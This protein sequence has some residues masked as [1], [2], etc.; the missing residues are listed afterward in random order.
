MSRPTNALT[1]VSIALATYNGSAF[2]PELLDSLERQTVRPDEVVIHDDGSQDQTVSIL[3]QYQHNLPLTIH[4]NDQSVGVVANFKRAVAG[5]KGDYVAF[6]DQDDVWLP[7]KIARSIEKLREIDGP[8]PAMVFTDLVV[9]DQHLNRIA[10]SYWQHRK[11]MPQK[12]TFASL[13]YGNFVT[14][15]TMVINRPMA[16]EVARMPDDVLMHDFW[17][18]CV[19]YG[20]GRCTYVETPTILYRQHTTNVTT[21]DKITLSTRLKRL[22]T[23]LQDSVQA[24][25]FLLP[26]V[27]QAEQFAGLYSRQLKSTDQKTLSQF[28]DLKN[29]LPLYRRLQAFKIKFLRIIS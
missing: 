1:T 17:I 18:T 20:V 24:A 21:N 13:L 2:L 9:V 25:Q 7:D 15:C 16:E 22:K 6:C 5:C 3:H 27:K 11:L 10:D 23:F 28:I 29:H 14:G 26:E 12:E 8:W 19:A 4:V